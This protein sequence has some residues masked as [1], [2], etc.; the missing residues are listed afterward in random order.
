MSA[1]TFE[2]LEFQG[3]LFQSK[4]SLG[5]CV[6]RCLTMG[7]GIAVGFKTRFGQVD[8]LRKQVSDKKV[9]T[10]AILKDATLDRYIYYLVT[11]EKYW[12]KP[13]LQTMRGSLVCVRDHMI[14][15]KVSSL[16]IPLIGC[17]LDRLTWVAV[18]E[19]IQEVFQTTNIKITV[20]MK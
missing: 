13:S 4:D 20:Y 12:Q 9:P 3:D 15:H 16:S 17:G 6:S 10:F 7:Q 11:K 1:P 5:H 8:N 2:I 14:E 19:I 18:K